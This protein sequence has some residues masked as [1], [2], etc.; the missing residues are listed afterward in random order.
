MNGSNTGTSAVSRPV[1]FVRKQLTCVT[2]LRVPNCMLSVVF[3]LAVL[4][5]HL[6]E[7]GKHVYGYLCHFYFYA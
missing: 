3:A 1:V 7:T 5:P 4:L 2:Y 6:P